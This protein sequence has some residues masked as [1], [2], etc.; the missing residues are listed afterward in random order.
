MAHLTT[1][2]PDADRPRVVIVGCGN[3]NRSD[4]GVG[5]SVV[6][7]LKRRGLDRAMDNVGVFD[8]GT[9]GMAV[10]FAARGCSSLI[11]VDACRSGAQPGAIFE[12]PG[13]AVEE[14]RRSAIG[15]HDFRW[16]DALAAGRQ[17]FGAA[18][19]RE[20]RVFLIEVR[21][22]ELGFELSSE[23]EAAARTVAGRIEDLLKRRA[24]GPRVE[25]C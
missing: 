7:L 11:V 10:M 5:T 25:V 8:A 21:S 3:P 14:R 23:V 19:P 18:F 6:R 16:D 15:L 2:N 4:D 24:E 17:I 1:A 13:A 20:V 12:V 9:D 22:L